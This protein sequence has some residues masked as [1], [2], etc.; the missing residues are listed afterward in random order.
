MKHGCYIGSEMNKKCSKCREEKPLEDFYKQKAGKFGR[1]AD[2]KVCAKAADLA[3]KQTDKGKEVQKKYNSSAKG[4]ARSEKYL[5]SDNGSRVTSA[6]IA[7]WYRSDNGKA[8]S[9]HKSAKRRAT[10]LQQTPAWSEELAIKRFYANCPE[11]YHVDH[12]I[13]LQGEIVSGLHVLGNLRYLPAS[14]NM[15][16]GNKFAA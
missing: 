4:L 9:A 10:K 15:S 3:Y 8:Y 14:E 13:P 16:K 6:A 12:D 1:R 11:G 7:D 5:E 2:C